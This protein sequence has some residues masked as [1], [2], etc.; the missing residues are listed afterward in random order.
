M[1]LT[2]IPRSQWGAR[3]PSI[4][5]EYTTWS[6]R[7]GVAF[8]YSGGSPTSTPR[9]LQDYA[10]DVK[11]YRDTHYNLF[12]DRAGNAYWGRDGWLA[13][14]AHALDQNTP[15]IGVCF[16]GRNVDVTQAAL[17]TMRAIYDE[18]CRLAGRTLR[19]A[20]HGQLPGQNTDCPGPR[21]LAWLAQGMPAT[22]TT[23][24]DDMFYLGAKKG[25]HGP[26]IELL[27]RQAVHA[28][29]DVGHNPD[30]SPMLDGSW[31]DNTSR[32]VGQGAGY[33]HPIDEITAE[34]AD[35]LL[36]RAYAAANS[37]ELV[38]SVS[39]GIIERLKS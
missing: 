5:V 37:P 18:A 14:A 24:G 33:D 1:T 36:A 12:V 6:H 15:W 27:Q 13:V 8:H 30:G 11:N 3:P 35:R 17:N 25:D 39:A 32:G 16:I 20:G 9:D 38:A 31:G 28:G 7:V 29:G 2:I 10:M 19:Y 21:I 23:I 22:N 26:A 4:P 34:V